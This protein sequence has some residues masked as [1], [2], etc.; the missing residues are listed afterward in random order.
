MSKYLGNL[1]KESL[2]AEATEVL[3]SKGG[4]NILTQHPNC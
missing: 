2:F 4:N 1:N 3:G